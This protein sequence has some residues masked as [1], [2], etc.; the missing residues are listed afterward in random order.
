M[1][2]LT[3]THEEPSA[4]RDDGASDWAADLVASLG[5][6]A[7]LVVDAGGRLVYGNARAKDY[8]AAAVFVGLADKDHVRFPDHLLHESFQRA[9]GLVSAGSQAAALFAPDAEGGPAW[10]ISVGAGQP[11][12]NRLFVLR[13]RNLAE[14]CAA[15]VQYAVACFGLTPA[16]SRVLHGTLNGLTPATCAQST[17]LKISTVRTHLAALFAKTQTSGQ[18]QLV[19]KVMSLPEL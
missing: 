19:V 15:K 2:W 8:L 6:D 13:I 10:M 7:V 14:V 3:S 12:R 16:E 1:T 5:G 9:L 4:P 17:G 18:A 11:R